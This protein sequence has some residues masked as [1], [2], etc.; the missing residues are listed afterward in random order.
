MQGSFTIVYFGPG[1][2]SLSQVAQD[3]CLLPGVINYTSIW[4]ATTK[5]D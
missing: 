5:L 2:C 1:E 4:A 3:K